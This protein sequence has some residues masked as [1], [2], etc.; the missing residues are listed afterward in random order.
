MALE[1][2][3][4]LPQVQRMGRALSYKMED[5]SERGQRAFDEFM[6]LNDNAAIYERIQ[7]ARDRDAGYRGAAPISID[8]ELLTGRYELPKTP[9]K[10]TIVAVD[11]SQ[12]YPDIHG[13]AFYYLTNIGRFTFYHGDNQLPQEYSEPV[14]YYADS[15]IRDPHD[16]LIT[17]ATVNARRT[18]GEMQALANAAWGHRDNNQAI[19]ALSDGPLLFW[20][21]RDVPEGNLLEKDYHGA[22]VHLHDTHTATFT[23][24]QHNTSLAGYID[25]PTSRFVVALLH[26]LSLNEEDV[27]RSVLQTP[28]DYEGLDDQWLFKRILKPGE[29]SALMI[30]QSP[31][32]KNYRNLIGESHEIVYF[33]L[34]VGRHGNAHLGRVEIPMWV[35]RSREAVNEVHA[36]II[37]QCQM[38]GNYPYALTR[39]DEIAVIRTPERAMLEELIRTELLRHKHEIEES[40]KLTGKLQTRTGRQSFGQFNHK[41]R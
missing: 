20:L 13:A 26:L 3:K 41:K 9:D 8:G 17:N 5:I 37:G 34:N 39:A 2:A 21:G 23:R 1:Y 27:R 18:V 32:N 15:D 33:Y 35:A 31:Q 25:R 19:L 14:L 29:R 24:H 28:G 30:Q 38:M 22:M 36:L 16:Q 4:V 6:E 7:L 10:A 40:A 12:I 11:G